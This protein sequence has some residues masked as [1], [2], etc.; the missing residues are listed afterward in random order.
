MNISLR[1]LAITAG[2]VLLVV[3]F[4]TLRRGSAAPAR[5]PAARAVA[6]AEVEPEAAPAPPPSDEAHA[7]ARRARDAM[8][9]EILEARRRHDAALAAA[10]AAAA[11]PHPA[12]AEPPVDE[13]GY[14]E[15][16]YIQQH[17]REDMFPLIKECYASALR[18]SPKLAGKLVLTFNI[19][20]DPSVGGI[21]EDADFADES[22]I[23][24]PEMST[25]V[26]ESMMT[27]T[28][29][30]PPSGGG[31]VKVTY[32]IAFSPGDDD[33]ADGGGP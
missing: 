29:D 14:Y 12:P 31:S 22:T 27:L 24:D 18:Q 16:S 2:A 7:E 30:K 23:K 28:F 19:V 1:S 8:R 13:P 20:G 5:K 26:R 6:T 17:V 11:A 3:G 4:L 21:V 10:K 33:E 32:P 9:R 15:P 25:C